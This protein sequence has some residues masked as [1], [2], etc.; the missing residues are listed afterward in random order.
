MRKLIVTVLV[1]FICSA[2]I[3]A[4][5]A[6]DKWERTT[7]FIKGVEPRPDNYDAIIQELE[8]GIEELKAEKEKLLRNKETETYI[9]IAAL[10]AT[11][12]ELERL[13]NPTDTN[14]TWGFVVLNQINNELFEQWVRKAKEW[15]LEHAV[16]W[17]STTI[18]L[19]ETDNRNLF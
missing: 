13:E 18:R 14:D 6:F 7:F 1:L 8:K 15:D 17:E 11:G 5:P 2:L 9:S 19:D 4:G 12:Y 10:R 3:W 16:L